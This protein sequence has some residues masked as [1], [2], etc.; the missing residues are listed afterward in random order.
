MNDRPSDDRL[1]KGGGAAHR[2]GRIVEAEAAYRT[3][4]ERQSLHFEARHMLGVLCR[5]KGRPEQVVTQI[6]LALTIQPES[7]E[8]YNNLANAYTDLGKMNTARACLK[9]ALRIQPRY[10]QASLTAAQLAWQAADAPEAF[11]LFSKAAALAPTPAWQ[12]SCKGQSERA[13]TSCY[14]TSDAKIGDLVERVLRTKELVVENSEVVWQALDT[15]RKNI[16][17]GFA[18]C[19]IAVRQEVFVNR[20]AAVISGLLQAA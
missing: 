15:F 5:A 16:K 8:A 9:R 12:F 11:E 6:S 20:T 2:A 17:A 3:V 19:L 10:F 13:L 4:I 14:R 18:D 7:A 1:L